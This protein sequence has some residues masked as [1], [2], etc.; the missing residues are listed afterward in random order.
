MPETIEISAP[1]TKATTETMSPPET[2]FASELSAPLQRFLAH[3]VEHGLADGL[4]SAEDFLEHFSP[5]AI[6]R[7]LSANPGARARILQET[8][9]VSRVIAER[10]SAENGGEDLRIA[11][12]AGV[13]DA[14]RVLALLDPDDRVRYLDNQLLWQYVIEP[15]GWTAATRDPETLRRL[16]SHTAYLIRRALDDKLLT[17]R[18]LVTAISVSTL[19]DRLPRDEIT[20]AL[21]R[22]LEDGRQDAPFM[23]ETLLEAISMETV[24]THIPLA[25]LWNWVIAAKIGRPHGLL[26]DADELFDSADAHPDR[27]AHDGDH[28]QSETVVIDPEGTAPD[29]AGPGEFRSAAKRGD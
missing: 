21:E 18:D 4:R 1:D 23:D 9:G 20:N 5:V 22:A 8:T 25:T 24:A 26:A 29:S 7:A 6:M 2:S 27:A 15:G 11:L 19:V 28:D 14:R 3:A 13:T 12:D 10:K 17:A 16:R